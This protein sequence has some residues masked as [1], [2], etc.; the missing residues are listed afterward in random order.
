MAPL[1]KPPHLLVVDDDEGLLI[2]M[3]ETLR[4]EGYLVDT[5]GSATAAR[6]W[7]DRHVPDLMI[8][9]L[10]LPDGS[11]PDLVASLQ[12]D[13]SAV[14]F[15]VVTGQGD[16]KVAV[17]VMKQGALDYVMKDTVLLD[18][19]PTVV[20][21]A[22]NAVAQEKALRAAQAEYRRLEREIVAISER[23]RH[24]I[25]ADLHDNLGQQLT[26]LE[27]MCTL[28]KE[29][30]RPH[31]ELAK[32]L[33]LMARM[34]REAVAQVRFLARGL[35]P[36]GAE[37]EALQVGLAGLAERTDALGRL[38]CR[39]DCPTPVSVAD[40]FVAGHLYRIAQEAVNN[41]VK[42]A[43]ARHA[44]IRLKQSGSELRLVVE[45]DGIG[46]PDRDGGPREGIGLGVMRHRAS[47]IG[48]QLTLGTRRGG[49]CVIRCALRLSS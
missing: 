33:D 34:L 2:L 3:A 17:E 1:D 37:P 6:A 38:R 29:D 25:G 21:R 43:K 5:A 7:L 45:D 24:S 36:V 20:R 16:E 13:R 22:L 4:G 32:R 31:P 26:A 28:A 48:A 23:E 42:H 41:A 39:F 14:P 27:L 12:R 19:L 11:G 44:V 35:V 15:A 46:L 47:L 40:P 10:K 49:G 18:R 9:D 30:A 8:L